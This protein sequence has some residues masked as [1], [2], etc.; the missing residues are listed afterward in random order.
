M[1][2]P[3]SHAPCKT[4]FLFETI[5]HTRT[6]RLPGP[7]VHCLFR[8]WM[9]TGT[10]RLLH[11][12]TSQKAVG[13][14]PCTCTPPRTAGPTYTPPKTKSLH[15]THHQYQL[16]A[17]RRLMIVTPYLHTTI[18]PSRVQNCLRCM[19]PPL[20][21]KKESVQQRICITTGPAFLLT[22]CS[23]V[24]VRES[25]PCTCTQFSLLTSSLHA[26]HYMPFYMI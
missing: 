5:R 19:H 6:C 15:N 20:N 2:A 14:N 9:P 17:Q 26:L 24:S 12:T 23:C 13:Y 3:R 10:V 1:N 7:R 25:T 21:T 8:P 16:R 11:I 18:Q 22:S 4:P